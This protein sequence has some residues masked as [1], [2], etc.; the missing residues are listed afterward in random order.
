VHK[1]GQNVQVLLVSILDLLQIIERQILPLK[2]GIFVGFILCIEVGA[3]FFAKGLL[4]FLKNNIFSIK[5]C[6]YK[7]HV[8]LTLKVNFF[9]TFSSF[10][11]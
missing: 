3:F 6:F 11:I 4:L 5:C 8:I 1:I 10:L 9:E 2:T 7:K